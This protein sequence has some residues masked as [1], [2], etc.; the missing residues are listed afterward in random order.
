MDI[1]LCMAAV[2][3]LAIAAS[4]G[5]IAWRALRLQRRAAEAAAS[6]GDGVS[7]GSSHG[8][9]LRWPSEP[10]LGGPV[11]LGDCG[12]DLMGT[13]DADRAMLNAPAERLR[14][15][16][17]EGLI[18]ADFGRRLALAFGLCAVAVLAI[19]STAFAISQR[20][21]RLAQ[22]EAA[23]NALQMTKLDHSRVGNQLVIR[24]SVHNPERSSELAD[25]VVVVY[26][27]DRTGAY[28]GSNLTVLEARRLAP[29]AASRFELVVPNGP[30]IG[31]YRVSFRSGARTLP[32]TDRRA[33]AE[34]EPVPD[35]LLRAQ[36][37]SSR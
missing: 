24:G 1:I 15:A 21:A 2:A 18:D 29:G 11:D 31:R 28:L 37:A 5:V 10:H 32:H 26:L 19:G 9:E 7:R 6:P 4:M 23:A 14:D 36:Q 13:A 17:G 8:C 35:R 27:F 20:T 22:A 16:G 3:A 33:A 25:V 30:A 12:A 34:A